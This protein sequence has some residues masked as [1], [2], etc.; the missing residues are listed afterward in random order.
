MS[1]VIREVGQLVEPRSVTEGHNRMLTEHEAKLRAQRDD[2]GRVVGGTLNPN[3][4]PNL[5]IGKGRNSGVALVNGKLMSAVELSRV[6]T[7]DAVKALVRMLKHD[8]GRVVVTAAEALLNRGWGK[9]TEHVQVESENNTN[10]RIEIVFRSADGR[11]IDH[12]EYAPLLMAKE[13]VSAD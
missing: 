7:V 9:P 13:D 8:D 12:S 3:G 10:S 2:K 6:H 1:R 5:P 4:N 11:V